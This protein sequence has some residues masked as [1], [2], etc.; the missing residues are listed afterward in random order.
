MHSTFMPLI[1]LLQ[2]L[3]NALDRGNCA[4]GIFIDFQ[5]AFDTVN[6]K[7]LLRYGIR[8]IALDWFSGYLKIRSQTAIFNERESEMKETLCGVPQGSILGPPL[9]LLYINDLLLVSK[10]LMALL[11]ADDTNLFCNGPNLNDLIEE[12]NAEL[13]LVY[14]RVNVNKISL[15]I[16]KKTTNF[17]LFMP[18]NF[19]CLKV[20][21]VADNHPIKDV[22]NT[23][24]LGVIINNKPKCKEH[25]EYI[26]KKIAKG[27]GVIIKTRVFDKVTL[28]S[29]YNSLILPYL[30]Y[31]IHIW[32]NAYRTHQQKLHVLQNNIVR[33]IAGVPTRN[34]P[35]PL[36]DEFNILKIKKLYIY[37]VGF[38]MY[39]YENDMLQELF[40]YMF[41][42]VKD[43]H[44][45]DT[46]IAITYKLFIQIYGTVRG[47][48]S[49]KYVGVR[50]WNYI[51][52]NM[53]TRCPI[54]SFKSSLRKL[55]MICAINDIEFLYWM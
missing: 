21:V 37:A 3:R 4:I 36:Y 48:K 29:L 6:H 40:K 42:K 44:D 2:N 25:I 24:F 49:V 28:L 18:N 43:V 52:Q 27:I 46:R 30:S 17:M 5:K 7:I 13:K 34:S 39:K 15:N 35:D 22:H 14:T 54:G 32:G 26:S 1:N 33:I 47:Q 50:T 8:G 20:S 12:I 23:K 51:L 10:L 41:V 55:C 19:L 38:C 45:H 11:F 16:E 31:C 9:V 53:H